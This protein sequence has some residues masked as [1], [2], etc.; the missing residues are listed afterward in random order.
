VNLH[1]ICEVILLLKLSEVGYI[2][3][4]GDKSTMHIR[5]TLY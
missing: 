3:V 5:V 4:F 2:E 1:D